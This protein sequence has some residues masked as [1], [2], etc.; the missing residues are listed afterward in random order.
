MNA[1]S[2]I[3]GMNGIFCPFQ[4]MFF[5]LTPRLSCF[6]VCESGFEFWLST[7]VPVLDVETSLQR[8]ESERETMFQR[9]RVGSPLPTMNN[10]DEF[11]DA[12]TGK[13]Y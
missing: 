4:C 2:K 5:K 13:T 11:Y 6:L 12:V 9:P 10:E 7:G 1:G 3:I 8:Q